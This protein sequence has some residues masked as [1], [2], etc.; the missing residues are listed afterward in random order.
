[1]QGGVF[2]EFFRE[3]RGAVNFVGAALKKRDAVAAGVIEKIRS[4]EDIAEG[5]NARVADGAI[6]MGFCGEVKNAA[7]MIFLKKGG[8]EFAVENIAV[9]EVTTWIGQGVLEVFFFSRISER[10]EDDELRKIGASQETFG[11]MRANKSRA[12]SE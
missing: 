10:V 7:E 4:A 6:N 2:G 5:E 9:N 12:A 1:M 8:D 3:W 11:K